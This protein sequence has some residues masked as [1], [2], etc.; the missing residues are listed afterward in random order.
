MYKRSICEI[1]FVASPQTGYRFT[2]TEYRSYTLF[3]SFR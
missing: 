3:K 2:G 1:V